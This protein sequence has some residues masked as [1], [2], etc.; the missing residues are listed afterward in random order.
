MT[1][2]LLLV[3]LFALGLF[4]GCE[5][6]TQEARQDIQETQQQATQDI[7]EAQDQAAQD[8]SEARQEASQDVQEAQQDLQEARQDAQSDQAAQDQQSTSDTDRA[9]A[10]VSVTPEQCRELAQKTTLSTSEQELYSACA[11]LDQESSGN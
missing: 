8:V 5:Q 4:V 2:T 11:N 1:R 6:G 9:P 7:N 3:P 10:S